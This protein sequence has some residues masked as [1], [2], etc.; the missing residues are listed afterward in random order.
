MLSA[1]SVQTLRPALTRKLHVLFGV[2]SAPH[3]DKAA[4]GGEDAF[5]ADETTGAFGVAD[6]VGGSAGEG[7][8]PGA[9]SRALLAHCERALLGGGCEDLDASGGG[10]LSAALAAARAGLGAAPLGGASTL[11]LGRLEPADGGHGTLRLLNIGDCGAMLLRPAARRM[12]RGGRVVAWPRTVLRTSEQ[13]H[14]F[15]CPYQLSLSDGLEQADDADMLSVQARPGDLVLAATDGLLDNLRDTEVQ[16]QIAAHLPAALR[17]GPSEARAG[18]QAAAEALCAAA[19]AIGRRQDE[20]GLVTPFALAAGAEGYRFDGGKL[21]D[22][23]VVVGV[24]RAGKRAGTGQRVGN[25]EG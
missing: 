12:G 15:N 25:L 6:G 16:A 20:P 23:V 21:D 4:R 17:P 19:A 22:V 10:R 18:V 13:T 3:P 24:V 2:S 1:R 8:D 5:F 9:F 7:A 14:Y 11:L